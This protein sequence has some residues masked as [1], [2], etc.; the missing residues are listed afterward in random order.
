MV[1]T[2]PHLV[3]VWVFSPCEFCY[4]HAVVIW[5]GKMSHSHCIHMVPLHYEFFDVQP[6]G[7]LGYK[8]AYISAYAGFL[9]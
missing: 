9:S 1:K 5:K 2:F 7:S 8:P 3:Q 6:S 4:A